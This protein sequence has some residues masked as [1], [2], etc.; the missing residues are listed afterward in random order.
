M[1]KRRR[2]ESN[3]IRDQV[4]DLEW[5][6]KSDKETIIRLKNVE[7]NPSSNPSQ[8][9][10]LTSKV[11]ENESDLTDIKNRQK[12]LDTGFLDEELDRESKGRQEYIKVCL[13]EKKKKKDFEKAEDK[14]KKVRSEEYWSATMAEG[15]KNKSS[16]RDKK[17]AYRYYMKCVDTIPDR[18]LQ[19]LRE[20]PNNKGYIWRDM[21]LF[22]ELPA[23]Q[24][25][26]VVLFQKCGKYMMVIH[27]YRKNE[28]KR[29]EKVGTQKKKLVHHENRKAIPWGCNQ[30]ITFL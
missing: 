18:T 1:E 4:R 5:Y 16:E 21:Y 30:S 14:V 26:P 17:S 25:Q 6:I 10:K 9:S 15:R 29:F 2:N 28:Y 24:G 27:E 20:M 11:Y 23:E 19:N 13:L 12:L 7:T 3:K 22:G 8:I